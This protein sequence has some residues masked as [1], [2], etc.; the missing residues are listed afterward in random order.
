MSAL[1]AST[2]LLVVLV[3][4]LRLR[5]SAA[6]AGGLGLLVAPVLSATVVDIG[7]AAD[8]AA[9]AAGGGAMAEAL[10]ATATVLWIVL[11]AL[12]PYAFQRLRGAI[13]R[14]RGALVGLTD[15]RRLQA[16][17]I[18]WFFGLFM[19]GAA[20]FGTL[21]ALAAPLLVGL[22]YEPVRAVTLAL[23]GHAAGT[24][25]SRDTRSIGSRFKS[26]STAPCLRSADIR[27]RSPPPSRPSS[28]SPRSPFPRMEPRCLRQR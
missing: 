19:D 5:R 11:P 17:L 1:L 15:D 24:P 16:I 7:A 14:I 3:G 12:A 25:S 20:G 21:V 10:H 2:P 6:V 28:R 26:R 8:V 9:L 27:R 13:E 22:G 23:L 4:M 18:A